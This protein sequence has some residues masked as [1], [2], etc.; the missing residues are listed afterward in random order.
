MKRSQSDRLTPWGFA[1]SAENHVPPYH[2]PWSS[3]LVNTP[4]LNDE[5]ETPLGASIFG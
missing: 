5:R 3:S 4:L 1:G 2:R